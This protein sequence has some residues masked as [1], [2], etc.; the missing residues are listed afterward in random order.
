MIAINGETYEILFK[1]EMAREVTIDDVKRAYEVFLDDAR[2]S[3][4]L[5]EYE[6]YFMFNDLSNDQQ[7]TQSKMET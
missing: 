6:Q 7:Q 5:H 2:F 4:N 1:R 3:N